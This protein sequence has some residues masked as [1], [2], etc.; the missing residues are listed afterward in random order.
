[1]VGAWCEGKN[2]VVG[3]LPCTSL[4]RYLRPLL[5]RVGLC[6]L[7]VP[8]RHVVFGRVL[9]GMDVLGMIEAAGTKSGRPLR[10]VRIADSGELPLKS[11]GVTVN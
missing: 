11:Q 5:L 10:D 4:V 2:V 7:L 8:G 6:F 1:M 3:A 9:D